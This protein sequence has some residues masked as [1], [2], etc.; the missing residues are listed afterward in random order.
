MRRIGKSHIYYKIYPYEVDI[1]GLPNYH[2]SIYAKHGREYH[3]LD[4]GGTRTK[5]QAKKAI[6]RASKEFRQ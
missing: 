6:L 2:W 1:P 3:N 4:S 5:G